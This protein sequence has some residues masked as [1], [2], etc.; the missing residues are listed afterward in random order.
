MR[1]ELRRLD[2]VT[3]GLADRDEIPDPVVKLA[4]VV[5]PGEETMACHDIPPERCGPAFSYVIPNLL[6]GPVSGSNPQPCGRGHALE[7]EI[8]V[9]RALVGRVGEEGPELF[10][11][12]VAFKPVPLSGNLLL[13]S[14][15]PGRGATVGE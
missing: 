2:Q 8:H 13:A 6:E 7:K 15:L 10:V 11:A 14:W 1:L 12:E 9:R 3:H 4:I 5:P